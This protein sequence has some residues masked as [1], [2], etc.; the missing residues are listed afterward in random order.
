MRISLVIPT[1]E[2]VETLRSCLAL[3][4]SCDDP[5]LEVVVSDNHSTDGTAAFLA[6]VEDP[7]LK[8]VRPEGRVAM[9]L[10]FETGLNAATGDYV[11][12]IGDDDGV[13]PSGLR[14][15]REVLQR[16]RPEVVNWE[17]IS[18]T[19]PSARPGQG[20]GVLP[21]KAKSVHGG[22]RRFPAAKRLDDLCRARLRNYK[23]TANI[24]HGCVSRAVIDRVR[25]ANGG[26]YF[27]G[28]IPDVYAGIANLVHMTGD[29][30]WLQHPVTFGGA[31]D[32]SNGAAQM[33]AVKV[34]GEGEAEKAAFERETAS[35]EG[36]SEI[37]VNIPSVDALTLDMLRLVNR[38]HAGGQL[39]V[40][41][42]AWMA[43]I[44][45]RLL[46]LPK[47]RFQQGM[48]LLSDYASRIG[49]EAAL[50]TARDAATHRG[51]QTAPEGGRPT[52][53][54]IGTG[55]IVL[56]HPD[57]LATVEDA[58]RALEQMLGQHPRPG[59]GIP[60][61]TRTL[62]WRRTRERA[63]ALARQWPA[64]RSDGT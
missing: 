19:W 44:V 6:S 22:M 28:A 48:A 34:P 5:D 14:L 51:A 35:D 9:R 15:L 2:R 63:R 55:R 47:D 45:A 26:V 42:K 39:V 57:A 10:N 62:A 40:D 27:G 33:S 11:I 24:Y 41:H 18:Y 8:V 23:D 58:A 54:S 1:R 53:S 31:S 64:H 52:S 16:D 25:A 61:V 43:R 32:R 50:G 36:T 49:E 17:L 30:L 13:L 56:A 12:V 3:A 60:F 59:G 20:C 29:L 37:H 4:L 7:R 21:V 46:R 38:T